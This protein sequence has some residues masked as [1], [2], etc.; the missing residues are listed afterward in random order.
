MEDG[1]GGGGSCW[2][3]GDDGEG[4]CIECCKLFSCV[5]V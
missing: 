1:G 3:E 2:G 4:G 5:N